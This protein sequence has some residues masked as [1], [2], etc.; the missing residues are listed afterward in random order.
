MEGKETLLGGHDV[1]VSTQHAFVKIVNLTVLAAESRVRTE[2]VNPHEMTATRVQPDNV[3]RKIGAG[4]ATGD[5][6]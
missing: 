1:T 4:H 2:G 5:A 3:V 6:R